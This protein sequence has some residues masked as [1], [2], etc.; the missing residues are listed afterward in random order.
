MR[1]ARAAV[2][3]AGAATQLSRTQVRKHVIYAPISGVVAARNVEPG[4]G[5]S[6]GTSLVRIVNL[7]PVRVSCEASELQVAQMRV[8]QEAQVTVDAL[9]GRQFVGTIADIAPQVREGQ[10]IYSRARA[11][12]QSDRGCCAQACSPASRIVTAMHRNTV[13]R[14]A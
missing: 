8:G 14:A 9:P 5:A 11:D 2:Q 13:H 10:R 3:Q 4:E 7:D 1:A 12:A 6:P